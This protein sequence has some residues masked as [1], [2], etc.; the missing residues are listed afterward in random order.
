MPSIDKP[1]GGLT[2][3]FAAKNE[4]VRKILVGCKNK[5]IVLTDYICNAIRFYEKNKEKLTNNNSLD[6]Q[7]LVRLEVEKAIKNITISNSIPAEETIEENVDEY[8]SEISDTK[9]YLEDDL[10]YVDIDED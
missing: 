10:D 9:N 1:G 6:I 3:T 5:K 8:N 7:E 2:L 4:D